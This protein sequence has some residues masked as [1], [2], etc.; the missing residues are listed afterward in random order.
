M[1]T[2]LINE[3]RLMIELDKTR[4]KE[5]QSEEELKT[6]LLNIHNTLFNYVD[7]KENNDE[8]KTII[9]TAVSNCLNRL[10]IHIQTSIK[11]TANDIYES[12]ESSIKN[13]LSIAEKISILYDI[14]EIFKDNNSLGTLAFLIDKIAFISFNILTFNELKQLYNVNIIDDII[15]DVGIYVVEKIN[16]FK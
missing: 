11:N 16:Y 12:S 4:I 3:S 5:I 1:L 7:K 13:Y 9:F 2:S 8:I 15:Y 10:L 6:L 14:S